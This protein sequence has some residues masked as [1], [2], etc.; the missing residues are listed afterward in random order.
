MS[1]SFNFAPPEE[2]AEAPSDGFKFGFG[3]ASAEEDPTAASATSTLPAAEMTFTAE[4]VKQAS[5]RG[6]WTPLRVEHNGAAT[7]LLRGH[8]SPEALKGTNETLATV[9]GSTDLAPTVYEGGFKLWECAVDLCEHLAAHYRALEPD[10]H[11]GWKTLELGCGHGLPG[12]LSLQA[13]ASV[14]LADYNEEVLREL[15]LPNVMANAPS[16][17]DR[18]RFFSGGW[19][20]LATGA[21]YELILTADTLY[22]VEYIPA[23]LAVICTHLKAP[24]G[25]ALVAAKTYYF[26]VGGGTNMFVD[27]VNQDGRCTVEVV[28]KYTDGR[29]N[30]REILKLMLKS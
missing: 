24:H 11:E 13:G 23:L 20:S 3:E 29:T 12:I 14:D 7:E 26:G 1:F 6:P 21:Q 8:V 18:T 17:I 28:H 27:M 5:T 25:I 10:A 15:T 16:A 4:E 22:A 30:V 9:V 2:S 19:D